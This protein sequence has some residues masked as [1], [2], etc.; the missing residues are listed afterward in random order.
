MIFLLGNGSDSSDCSS[1]V[2]LSTKPGSMPTHGRT[3][4]FAH[5]EIVL[6]VHSQDAETAN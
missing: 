3:F 2:S 4:T 5:N 6:A 1:I